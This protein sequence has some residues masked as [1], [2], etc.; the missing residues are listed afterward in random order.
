VP[1]PLDTGRPSRV[2]LNFAH[3][4]ALNCKWCYVPF[5]EPPAKRELVLSV[6]D[7][8]SALGFTNLTLGG[9][10]PFQYSYINDVVRLACQSGLL[11]HIDTHARSLAQS[12]KNADLIRGCVALMGLPLDGPNK[13][14]H[15]SMRG[16][17]GH[18]RIVMRRSRWL[19]DNGVRLKFNTLVTQQNSEH[20]VKTA[21]LV[22][23]L[24]PWRWS[25]YQYWP[26]GPAGR[27]AGEHSIPT[28]V[29]VRLAAQAASIAGHCTTSVEIVDAAARPA[30]YPV[31]HHDGSVFVPSRQDVSALV[32]ICSIF[33]GD[34]RQ[35]IDDACVSE[36]QDGIA[37][38]ESIRLGL[39]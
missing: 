7:R 38:Y 15:D 1:R 35:R 25:I 39:R 11:V 3:R 18:F 16:L 5:G 9:G 27:V 17:A 13:F 29:F 8:I 22:A 4:C 36:R 2:V 34:A 23:G 10:D 32:P 24:R 30:T 33:E 26:L 21:H 28:D 6:V 12:A 31:V 37:R 19:L 14:V 20:L